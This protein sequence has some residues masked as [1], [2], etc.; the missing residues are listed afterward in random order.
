MEERTGMLTE[1]QEQFIAGLLDKA[2][3][4][5][6]PVLESLDGPSFKV[7]VSVIDNNLIERIPQE[8]QNP[9]EPIIDAA[10]AGQWEEAADKIAAFA[11]EKIDI[12]GLDELSEQLIFNAILQLILG[13]IMGQV[14]EFRGAATKE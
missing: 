9:I 7:L 12:P 2:I 14:E 13:A 6:N 4:F 11:N 10:I 3:T 5:K 8:W 1:Q